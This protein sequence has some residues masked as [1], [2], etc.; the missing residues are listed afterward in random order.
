MKKIIEGKLYNTETAEKIGGI[1][2]GNYGDLNY[3]DNELYVTKKGAYFMTWE[4]GANSQYAEHIAHD[5]ITGGEGMAVMTE[6]EAK[7]WAMENL[8]AEEYIEAFGE[9]EEA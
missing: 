9:V 5:K 2:H 8:D 4:G 7:N 3:W 1:Y 6:D